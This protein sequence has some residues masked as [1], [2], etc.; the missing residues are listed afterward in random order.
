MLNTSTHTLYMSPV[1]HEYTRPEA[2][3]VKKGPTRTYCI[4][5]RT[6]DTPTSATL[7][8]GFRIRC[9]MT[10]YFCSQARLAASRASPLVIDAFAKNTARFRFLRS[11]ERVRVLRFACV[12]ASFPPRVALVYRSF[13]LIINACGTRVHLVRN[14]HALYISCLWAVLYHV[15]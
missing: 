14:A 4:R 15:C 11:P 1:E 12:Q 2:I 8:G 6:R 5:C 7:P 10:V 9:V 13:R 3:F